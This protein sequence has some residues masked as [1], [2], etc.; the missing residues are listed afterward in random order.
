MVLLRHLAIAFLIIL[1]LLIGGTLGYKFIEGWSLLDS[2]YMTVITITTVG[3]GEVYHLSRQGRI[4]TVFL[5]LFSFGMMA[6]IVGNI[7]QTI[8]AG[9]LRKIL[10]RRKLEKRVKK[11]K[12]H[13]ILC[14]Y[15]RIGSFIA[16]EFGRENVPFVVIEKDLERIKLI[17]EDG[18]PYVEGDATEDETLIRAGVEKAKALI[19]SVR[20]DADN[21][22]ITLSARSLNP[23]LY[24]LSRA[25]EE[26]AERKLL[27][28]GANR[29][30]SPYLMGAARMVNAVLRPNVVDFVDL[31]VQKRHLELQLEEITVEDDTRFRGKP[32]RESGIRRDLGLIVVAIRKESGEMIF[33]PSSETL[34]EKGDI[35]IVLGERKHLEM[36]EQLVRSAHMLG[37]RVS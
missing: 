26:G 34:I 4:F 17:E 35:L 10:G 11:L 2:L 27:S 33:N 32:L 24:I 31:V 12:N 6:Y 14:G 36:L 1:S 37:E 21:L 22:Y 30:V 9:Q 16:K 23:N 8:I 13:F 29:V 15:G 5:I 7:S 3:Y 20:S 28:A 25:D 18:F 19:A